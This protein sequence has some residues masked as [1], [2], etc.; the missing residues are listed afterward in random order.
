MMATAPA[1]K[2]TTARTANTPIPMYMCGRVLAG[3]SCR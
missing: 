3:N 1:I 2:H